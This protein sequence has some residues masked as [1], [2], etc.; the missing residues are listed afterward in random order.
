MPSV[1]KTIQHHQEHLQ[2]FAS[3]CRSR[4]IILRSLPSSNAGQFNNGSGSNPIR[5]S[6][7]YNL[8]V[9][10]HATCKQDELQVQETYIGHGGGSESEEELGVTSPVR[11]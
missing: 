10:P 7:Y 11:H 4:S 1:F 5:L 9:P 6:V 3:K 2:M 8:D